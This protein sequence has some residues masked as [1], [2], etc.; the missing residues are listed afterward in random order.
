MSDN[1]CALID[2]NPIT[3]K[4]LDV[5]VCGE[6]MWSQKQVFFTCYNSV[7]TVHLSIGQTKSTCEETNDMNFERNYP[8]PTYMISQAIYRS[9]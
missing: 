8:P 3:T 9:L 2:P 5:Q 1:L 7:A 6:A 4:I